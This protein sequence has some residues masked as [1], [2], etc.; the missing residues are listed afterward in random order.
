[1]L[2]GLNFVFRLM[3]YCIDLVKLLTEFRKLTKV[4]TYS[5]ACVD[6]SHFSKGTMMV[7]GIHGWLYSN[8]I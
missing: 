5:S 7:L 6:L 2:I 8:E 1:M 4:F 3:T